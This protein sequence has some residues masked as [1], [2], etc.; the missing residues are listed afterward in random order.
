VAWDHWTHAYG[1]PVRRISA[2]RAETPVGVP[3]YDLLQQASTFLG[4]S[5][6]AVALL[7]WRARAP[8]ASAGECG[9]SR[10]SRAGVLAATVLFA[11]ALAFWLTRDVAGTRPALTRALEAAVFGVVVA[12]AAYVL[13]WRLSRARGGSRPARR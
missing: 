9:L 8:V 1:W 10:R 5:V 4:V 7:R 12:L 2:L 13:G 3:V 11:G 6:I